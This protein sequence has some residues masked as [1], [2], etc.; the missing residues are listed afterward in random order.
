MLAADSR[1]DRLR[2]TTTTMLWRAGT[3]ADVLGELADAR[4]ASSLCPLPKKRGYQH[5]AFLLNAPMMLV[6]DGAADRV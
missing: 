1:A 6:G 2:K 3:G 5:A 4:W